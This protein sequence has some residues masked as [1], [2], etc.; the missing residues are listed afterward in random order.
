[1]DP[2]KNKAAKREIR[3]GAPIDN[4][5]PLMLVALV[6]DVFDRKYDWSQSSKTNFPHGTEARHRARRD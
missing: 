5:H 2:A 6:H 4:R 3:A 1:M